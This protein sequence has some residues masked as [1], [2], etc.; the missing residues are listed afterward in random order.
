MSLFARCIENEVLLEPWKS[1]FNVIEFSAAFISNHGFSP[2]DDESMSC[3]KEVF[4]RAMTK[5]FE[6]KKDYIKEVGIQA[7]ENFDLRG[8]LKSSCNEKTYKDAVFFLSGITGHFRTLVDKDM[9]RLYDSAVSHKKANKTICTCWKTHLKEIITNN[10]F[11]DF[12]K[13]FLDDL[14][15]ENFLNP[16]DP[17]DLQQEPDDLPFSSK[18]SHATLPFQ[19][20]LEDSGFLSS[21]NTL[22]EANLTSNSI[23]QPMSSFW[24]NANSS[25]DAIFQ[26]LSSS[27]PIIKGQVEVIHKLRDGFIKI[28][29]IVY[30][31]SKP[32]E[33]LKDEKNAVPS[34]KRKLEELEE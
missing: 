26:P 23:Y 31:R 25:S 10:N 8:Q 3:S 12:S 32:N 2:K 19:K 27:S 30:N 13:E 34:M 7:K 14:S 20:S 33:D 9:D 24:S 4:K 28:N 21:T 17:L 22:S 6:T 16:V 5:M 18:E 11:N 15:N 1:D 29:G